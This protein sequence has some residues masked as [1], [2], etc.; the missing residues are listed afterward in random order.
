MAVDTSVYFSNAMVSPQG[1]GDFNIFDVHTNPRYAIGTKIKR[2]DGNEY[3]Y[4]SFGATVAAGQC[5]SQDISE[6]SA[7]DIDIVVPASSVSGTDGAL[8]SKFVE[9]TEASI[10]A[11]QF[12]GGYLSIEDDTG[13][14]YMYRIKGNTATNDPATGNVRIELYDPIQVALVAA[15]TG[16]IAGSPYANLEPSTT[17]DV[18]VGG[19]ACTAFAAGELGWIQSAGLATVLTEGTVVL[20][21]GCI[22]APNDAGAVAPAVETDILERVGVCVVVGAD[23]EH[24][25]IKLTLK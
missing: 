20:G 13:E 6:S 19:V 24:S 8:G 14:G 25:I 22:T 15:T 12:A 7:A 1:G 3:I 11:D 21:S 18:L 5:V 23:T 16:N 17:T 10:A 4:G 2:Q 9:V